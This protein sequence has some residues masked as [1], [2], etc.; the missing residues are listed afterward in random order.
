MGLFGRKKKATPEKS[1]ASVEESSGYRAPTSA[2]PPPSASGAA[3]EYVPA[4]EP[5]GEVVFSNKETALSPKW[6]PYH[7]DQ[8]VPSQYSKPL[9]DDAAEEK[10]LSEK[11]MEHLT[12]FWASLLGCFGLPKVFHL[13]LLVGAG[14]LA[15]TLGIIA[16]TGPIS[17][18]NVAFVGNSF[19]Y[20]NDLPRFVEQIADG[21]I[22][23]DSVLHNYASVLEIIMTGNGMWNKWATKNAMIGGVKFTTSSGNIAYLYDMGAC[24]VPQLLTGH[25]SLV[26]SGDQSGSFIDDGENPCFQQDAYLEYQESFDYTGK[27]DFV[28]VT[29]QAKRMALDKFRH[30]ALAAFNYTY[31][32]ILKKQRIAP[33]IVQPHAYNSEATNATGLS[34][35]PTFTALVLEGAE[36]YKQYLN[37]RLGFFTHARIAPVGNAF[38]A[39]WEDDRSMYKK[40]FLDDGVHPSA[41]GTFLYGTV[42][43]ATMTGH[44]PKYKKVVVDDMETTL[45]GTARRLQASSSNV[46]FPTKDEAAY[47]YKIAKKVHRGHTPKSIRHFKAAADA[48]DFLEEEVSSTNYNGQYVVDTYSNQYTYN[49]YYDGNAYQNGEYNQYYYGENYNA[50]GGEYDDAAMDDAAEQ[51]NQYYYQQANGYYGNYGN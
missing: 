6:G 7:D 21:H 50:Y 41:F 43:Y 23:Q 29:D 42:I 35:L 27:W 38:L 18:L 44:M 14:V 45:F 16:S 12:V 40:L 13:P 31:G 17:N 36:V 37:K 5:E 10:P 24:S 34:D 26:T 11:I 32:P 8:S 4:S 25:D 28:V 20:V 47:L 30:E 2:S 48:E 49:E 3:P 33:V 22:F 1:K 39:V 19:F 9:T 46:G 51:Q 15:V